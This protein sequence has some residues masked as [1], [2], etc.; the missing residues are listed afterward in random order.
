MGGDP[1]SDGKPIVRILF[2]KMRDAFH[3]LPEEEKGSFMHRDRQNLDSLGMRAI[4][5]IDCRWSNEEWDFIG[6]EE[7]PSLE[8]LEERARFERDQLCTYRYT[9]SQSFVG[10]P[11]SFAE[12]GKSQP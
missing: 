5:M 10:T 8:A 6:V 4:S 7:W 3:C 9:D 2:V 12:Y 11:V 1:M